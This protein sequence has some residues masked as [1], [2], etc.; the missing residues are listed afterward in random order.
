MTLD[1]GCLSV[2]HIYGQTKRADKATVQAYDEMAIGLIGMDWSNGPN[3]S[4]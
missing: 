3:F 1:E 4:T 2:R